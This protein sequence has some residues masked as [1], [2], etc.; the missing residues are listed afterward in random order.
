MNSRTSRIVAPRTRRAPLL[1]VAW[2]AVLAVPVV[3]AA[4]PDNC[5]LCHQFRGL[6]RYVEAEDRLH[7]FFVDPDYQVHLLGPHARLACTDC[8]VR[9]EVAV[10]PHQPVTKVNCTQTCHLSGARGEPLRFSHD[11]V[12]TVLDQSVHAPAGFEKLSFENGPLLENNQSRCLYCHDEPVFRTPSGA[13]LMGPHNTFDRCDACH[14]DQI[15]IDTDYM[16]RHVASRLQPSRPPLEMAQVCAACHADAKVI[17]EFGLP[18]AVASFVRSFH[19]KAAL[20][21]ADNAANCVDCHVSRGADAHSILGPMNPQSSVNPAHVADSC[22]SLKCHPGADLAIASFA[23]HLDLPTDHG[24]LEFLIAAAF[25]VLT[26]VSFGPSL[27]IC[28]L[29]LFQIVIGRRPPSEEAS[30]HLVMKVLHTPGGAAKLVRFTLSQRIQHWILVVLFA[31]LAI[32]GFPLKFADQLWARVVVESL[33]GLS[34]TRFVHHW[35]GLALVIG[36]AA[37]FVYCIT[38]TIR[39]AKNL[40]PDGKPVGLFRAFWDMPM[41]IHPADLLKGGPLMLYLLGLKREPPTFGRFTIKEKLEYIGVFW[42]T[43]LLG[44]TGIALWGMQTSTWF[45]SG[46]L[47]NIAIIAHTYEAFLAIIHVG[48]LHIVNVMFS[49]NVF[50]LSLATITGATPVVE[51]AEAHSEFVEDAAHDLGIKPEH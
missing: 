20:L 17:A 14:R 27:V 5:L 28:L 15:S 12:A 40:R 13:T 1:A 25:I 10:I 21:G 35:A 19:G 50:P 41:L 16:L 2:F 29:E 23:V 32:T 37:H 18:N 11:A 45:V 7:L 33:G 31:A 4:D 9:D 8:H 49:P 22:R 30:H 48:I 3:R 36:F 34:V 51:L 44:I 38:T 42:G 24:T 43:T 6:S 46:R 39:K 47:L 26:A